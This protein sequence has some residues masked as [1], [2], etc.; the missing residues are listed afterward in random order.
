MSS[1][2]SSSS[3]SSPSSSSSSSIFAGS[4]EL[5]A[6]LEAALPKVPGAA[7]LAAEPKPDFR[8]NVLVFGPCRWKSAIS[9]RI[10]LR[11]ASGCDVRFRRSL[12]DQKGCSGVKRAKSWSRSSSR[13]IRAA[14]SNC[15]LSAVLLL[16][17]DPACGLPTFD[18][19]II[20]S[21]LRIT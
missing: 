10:S 16:D 11:Y 7:A 15:C 6:A 19:G 20:K 5:D 4:V 2:S 9:P 18:E 21:A 3:S 13:D 1:S 14:R 17:D 12:S 8:L